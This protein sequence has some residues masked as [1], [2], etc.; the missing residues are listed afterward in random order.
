MRDPRPGLAWSRGRLLR[1]ARY[2]AYM[3]SPAWRARRR[4]WHDEWVDRYGI[5]PVCLVCGQAWTRGHCDL[6][7]ASYRRLGAEAF[8]DLLPLCRAD[9][10]ALHELWDAS[11]AWRCMGRQAASLA[12]IAALRRQ[13]ASPRCR[14]A[15]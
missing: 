6:H 13:H 9:H 4:A 15:S 10:S 2:C 12:I 11:S 3:D 7:H 5:E 1:R 14:P 8:T